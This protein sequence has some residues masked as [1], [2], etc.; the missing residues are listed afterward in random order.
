MA[1]LRLTAYHS[2]KVTEIPA[3]LVS[4]TQKVQMKGTAPDCRLEC[5][6]GLHLAALSWLVAQREW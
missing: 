3:D 5:L 2:K 1:W 6:L 4:M